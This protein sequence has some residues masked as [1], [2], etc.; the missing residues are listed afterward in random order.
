LVERGHGVVIA[1]PGDSELVR[2]ARDLAIPTDDSITFQRG[3]RPLVQFRDARRMRRLLAE[4]GFDVVHTHGSQD[5]WIVAWANRPK[6]VPVVRT[7]H[8][9]FAI[10]DH[11]LNRWLYG[12]VFDRI[13]C[14][15]NAIIEQCAAKSYMARDRLIL[16]HS[17]VELD[18]YANPDP[19]GVAAWRAK[20]GD[21]RP[22]VVIVGRLREE[23]GHRFLFAATAQLRRDF[24]KMLLIVAGDGSL[25]TEFEERVAAL[26]IAD[27]VRFLGFRTDIPEILAAADLFVMPSL[28]EGLGTAAIEASA[29]G[30]PIVAS[31]VGGITDVIRD[32]ET[33]RLVAAGDAGDLARAM[34][35]V[36]AD[37]AMAD[38]LAQAARRYAFDHF[39]TA[40]LVEKNIAVYSQLLESLGRRP[41]LPQKTR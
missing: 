38:R 2:R 4:G 20:W 6:R 5:S 25:R 28:A 24:P 36:L 32:G 15:S 23:K 22:V 31:R 1:A 17:A 40:A 18:R 39:T 37:R 13:I 9:I 33:G 11:V 12:K 27:S 29:A 41:T 3:F 19:A 14:I 26:G 34:K 7:K 16:I 10:S 21:R 35:E 30:R 8:N